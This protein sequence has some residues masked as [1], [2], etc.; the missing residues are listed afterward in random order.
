M[1]RFCLAFFLLFLLPASLTWADKIYSDRYQ[2]RDLITFPKNGFFQVAERDGK[3]WLVTPEGNAFISIGINHVQPYGYYAPLLGYS[4]YQKEILKRYGDVQG[5]TRDTE[6]R[7]REWGFNTIGS[8]SNTESRR[9]GWG[10]YSPSAEGG[11]K[12]FADMPYVVNLTLSRLGGGDWVKGTFPD[13]F[14]PEWELAVREETERICR[15]LKDDPM[16]IGYFTDNEL[17]WGPD[18]R[19][20]ETLL[21][22]YLG[23]SDN[24]PGRTEAETFLREKGKISPSR[25][26]ASELAEFDQRVAERYFKVT[27]RSIREV[28]PN[29]LIL[30]CRFHAL[31][32]SPGIIASCGKYVDVVSVNYYDMMPRAQRII[33][34]LLNTVDMTDW[35]EQYARL[36]GRPIMTTE[37][38]YRAVNSGLPNTKGASSIVLTQ[39]N[40]ADRFENYIINFMTKPW[41]VGYHWFN[42]VDEPWTGR[43][44]GENG[45]YGVVNARDRPYQVL[46][47]RMQKVNRSAYERHLS[48]VGSSISN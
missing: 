7:L 47:E 30:G 4:P 22:M 2:G 32:V 46:V 17:H 13:V 34:D 24:S 45:N 41:A 11:L 33:C 48:G 1:K 42:Y 44:D 31:G 37:F 36:S 26:S 35:L 12:L 5:W 18:W 15:P 20:L 29:H 43:H 14:D 38:S 16:L 39:K 21:Q 27:C 19:G 23:F 28:D 3:W 8:W 25:L 10:I 40:R 9:G 6:L